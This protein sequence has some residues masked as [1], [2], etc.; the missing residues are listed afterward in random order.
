LT[1]ERG[2]IWWVNFNPIEG[3]EQAGKRPA[4]VVSATTFNRGP[5]QLIVVAPM[6]TRIR[7][8]PLHIAFQPEDCGTSNTLTSPG[9]IRCDQIRTVSLS[10]FLENAPVGHLSPNIM[11]R[12]DNALRALLTLPENP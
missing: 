7:K 1:P 5:Q 9:A 4:L 12:V 11:S 8:L 3:H 6:T 2:D 10:R